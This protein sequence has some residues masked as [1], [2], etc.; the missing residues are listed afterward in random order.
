ML[1]HRPSLYQSFAKMALYH[2]QEDGL[3]CF[4][5]KMRLAEM[6]KN[7]SNHHLALICIN[8]VVNV[9][10][11]EGEIGQGEIGQGEIGKFNAK[12][13]FNELSIFCQNLLRTLKKH[14]EIMIINNGMLEC[15]QLLLAYF[16][17]EYQRI[18]KL[19]KNIFDVRFD[20]AYPYT[21]NGILTDL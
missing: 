9:V 8:L 13:F 15:N 11:W 3:A 12:C 20:D 4:K 7:L 21:L 6:L 17:I 2:G 5:R 16:K 10:I 19:Y 1:M 14:L 18:D